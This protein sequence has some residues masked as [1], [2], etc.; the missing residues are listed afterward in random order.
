MAPYFWPEGLDRTAVTLDNFVKAFQTQGYE[1]CR[2]DSVEIGFEKVAIY[3]DADGVPTH[4]AHGSETGVW[5]S[6][7]GNMEDIEHPSPIVVAGEHYGTPQ[8]FLR[9]RMGR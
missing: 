3:A 1:V 2:D 8:A 6:K 4:A 7:L 5:S 9:R